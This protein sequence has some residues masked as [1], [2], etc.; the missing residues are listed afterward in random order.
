[1]LH[2]LFLIPVYVFSA[3]L[4]FL[5]LTILCRVLRLKPA[6]NTLAVTAVVCGLATIALPLLDGVTLADYTGWRLLI[7]VAAS[8]ALAAIDTLLEP[9]LPLPVDAEL[10][11]L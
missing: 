11:E 1:V 3:I 4:V 2:W 7:I 6:A 5:A 8:F 9:L 10:A